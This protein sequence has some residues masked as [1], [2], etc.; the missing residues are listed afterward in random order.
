MQCESLLVLQFVLKA[1]HASVACAKMTE[2]M[3]L[4]SFYDGIIPN[5]AEFESD[6]V[7]PEY[8]AGTSSILFA[9]WQ[10]RWLL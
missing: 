1:N 6:H 10:T 7:P 2:I 5:P 4:R 8:Q 9:N 3:F